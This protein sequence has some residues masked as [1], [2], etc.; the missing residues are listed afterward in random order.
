[1]TAKRSELILSTF[2]AVFELTVRLGDE[3]QRGLAER[4]LTSSRAEV[5]FRLHGQGPMV[6]R[7]L[8]QALR[9]TPRHVTQLVD[10][11]ESVGLVARQQHPTDRRAV[12]VT[13]TAKGSKL[14][15]RIDAEREQAARRMLGDVSSADLESAVTVLRTVIDRLGSQA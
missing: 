11:L 3:M 4:G 2:D 8:S 10:Q 9:C 14:A 15:A 5:I 6:Q 13:L 12:L 7:E 1:M